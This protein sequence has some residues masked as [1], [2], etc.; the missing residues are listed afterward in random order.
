MC[1]D[2]RGGD[3]SI[4]RS[5]MAVPTFRSVNAVTLLKITT[6]RALRFRDERIGIGVHLVTTFTG[7]GSLYVVDKFA[8]A[9]LDNVRGAAGV[10]IC[11]VVGFLE[12]Y[13]RGGG[14]KIWILKRKNG[15]F[16]GFQRLVLL[17]ML[18]VMRRWMLL[19]LLRSV[20][21]WL[22]LVMLCMLLVLM[23][24]RDV[25]LRS[26]VHLVGRVRVAIDRL[27]TELAGEVDVVQIL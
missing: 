12:A 9:V 23:R 15:G 11:E 26:G 4:G 24:L 21:L 22:R 3:R 25:R 14:R 8:S 18:R 1:H 13:V 19:M 5:S 20:L 16:R 6:E 7:G 27:M 2:V 17:L 10:R